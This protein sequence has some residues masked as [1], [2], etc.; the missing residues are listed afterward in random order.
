[1]I[2]FVRYKKNKTKQN[3]SLDLLRVYSLFFQNTPRPP[4]TGKMLSMLLTRVKENTFQRNWSQKL[5]FP[6]PIYYTCGIQL[7][8]QVIYLDEIDPWQDVPLFTW[9]KNVHSLWKNKYL[10]LRF[11]KSPTNIFSILWLKK[12]NPWACKHWTITKPS[13]NSR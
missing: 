4:K 11:P 8:L 12:K 13:S 3:H 1:M 7:K 5:A 6:I 10:Y 2:H 9:Q